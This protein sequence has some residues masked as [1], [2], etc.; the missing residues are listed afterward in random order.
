MGGLSE[1]AAFVRPSDRSRRSMR[2]LGVAKMTL[3]MLGFMDA[4]RIPDPDSR[5]G[6][7]HAIASSRQSHTA[8]NANSNTLHRRPGS[9]VRGDD[10]SSPSEPSPP[11]DSLSHPRFAH[12]PEERPTSGGSFFA[13]RIGLFVND[14]ATTETEP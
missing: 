11:P 14:T 6:A 1:F 9:T 7:G 3:R 4:A 13:L 10:G 5:F 2:K 8:R 12:P